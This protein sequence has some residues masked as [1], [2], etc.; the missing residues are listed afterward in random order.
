MNVKILIDS[1]VRQTTV[2][3][4]QLA[5]TG[6]IRAP[7]AHIANQVFLELSRELDAQGVSR[8]V[9]ADMFGM[10]L[11]TYLRRI[12]WLTESSTERGRTLWEAVLDYLSQGEVK[13]RA[14]VLKRFCRDEEALVRG[15]LHDLTANGLVFSSGTGS[16]QMFRATTK[17]E[18]MQIKLEDSETG[19]DELLWA[20]IYRDGP[21]TR[22]ELDEFVAA[23]TESIDRAIGRLVEAG[24]IYKQGVETNP[25]FASCELEVEIG[26]AVGWEA[27]FFDHYQSMVKT[28]CQRLAK[29]DEPTDRRS[30]IG[31]ST[32]TFDV[33][34]GHPMAEEVYGCLARFREQHGEL[35]ERIKQ[36]NSQHGFP[37]EY[38]QVVVYGG[39]CIVAQENTDHSEVSR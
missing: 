14:Q 26:A 28:M 1:I 25:S 27:A 31:G 18:Q 19:L 6:G 33:W 30:R 9:S 12:Q 7:L 38:E 16:G 35:Y 39:Q 24:R 11:R 34:P 21:L 20:F 5:T 15:V 17:A 32:Y 37:K 10:A 13:S 4:A 23:R 22:G 29:S 8:K 2:L 36:Y 3:I